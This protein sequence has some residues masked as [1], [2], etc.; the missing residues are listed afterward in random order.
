M[1]SA[2]CANKTSK[3]MQ[4]DDLSIYNAIQTELQKGKTFYIFGGPRYKY[5]EDLVLTLQVRFP[6][7]DYTREV[8]LINA[9]V[10]YRT[11]DYYDAISDYELFIEEQPTHSKRNYAVYKI[12]K[13]Y[14]KLLKSEDK[15]IDPAIK[16]IE[17]NNNLSDDV[18]SSKYID[19]IN[20]IN[21]KAKKLLLERTLYIAEFYINKNSYI[22]SLKRITE[23]EKSIKD[24]IEVNPKAQYIKLLST[25]MLDSK[26]D[27]ISLINEYQINFPNQKD[28]IEELKKILY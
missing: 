9:D 7:S 20:N 4:G 5:I 22:S 24:L 13:S 12:I 28:Y 27:K 6:Y 8:N 26:A 1:L 14:E 16:I 2:S 11:K 15:D 21:S 3:L 23:A 10:S 25:F 18:K 19:Q 17:I